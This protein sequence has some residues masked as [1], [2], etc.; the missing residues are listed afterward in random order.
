MLLAMT[1]LGCFWVCQDLPTWISAGLLRATTSSPSSPANCRFFLVLPL[2]NWW[3]ARNVV[4]PIINSN[5]WVWFM[6]SPTGNTVASYWFY[7]VL[8]HSSVHSKQCG[9]AVLGFD[10][11]SLT[12]PGSKSNADSSSRDATNSDR[13]S[14]SSTE[15]LP[16]NRSL[17]PWLGKAV[18]L[19]AKSLFPPQTTALVESLVLEET[20]ATSDT[21]S[22]VTWSLQG[23]VKNEGFQKRSWKNH[24]KSWKIRGKTHGDIM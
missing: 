18:F 4:N 10:D 7:H 24:G 17:G 21:G 6:K 22:A 2:L 13:F 9:N 19:S 14:A 8:P 20:D 12:V 23:R 1:Q 15:N 16:R 5:N 11:S 3:A